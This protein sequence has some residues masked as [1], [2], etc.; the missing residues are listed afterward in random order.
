M[1]VVL[2]MPIFM[3]PAAETQTRK[4]TINLDKAIGYE[5]KHGR[6]LD[7]KMDTKKLRRTVSNRLSA[8]RSRVRKAQ[9]IHDMESKV[10]ELENTITMVRLRVESVKENWRLL[11]QQNEALERLVQIRLQEANVAQMVAEK[12]KAELGRLKGQMKDFQIWQFYRQP[13]PQP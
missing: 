9:H 7:P 8:Q 10:T 2:P 12:N 1:K 6:K 3:A 5:L 13:Q 11:Q 4:A